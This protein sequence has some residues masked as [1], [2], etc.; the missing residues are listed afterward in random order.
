MWRC[1]YGYV[2]LEMSVW[3]LYE[4]MGMKV[5]RYRCGDV[6]MDM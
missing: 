2:D 5:W 4:G 3:I 1:K 6:S